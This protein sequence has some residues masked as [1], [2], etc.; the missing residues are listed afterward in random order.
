MLVEEVDM[1]GAEPAKRRICHVTDMV[2][3]A[4]GTD[5]LAVLDVNSEFG[6]DHH[7]VPP[8]L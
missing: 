6:R 2:G 3:P 4:V 7:L 8:T 5:R 1:I